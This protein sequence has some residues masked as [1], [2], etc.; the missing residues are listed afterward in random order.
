MKIII[1]IIAL[2]G[3]MT[4]GHC[5]ESAKPESADKV[6]SKPYSLTHYKKAPLSMSKSKSSSPKFGIRTSVIDLDKNCWGWLYYG[7]VRAPKDAKV[8][9][10]ATV[11][12]S[13]QASKLNVKPLTFDIEIIE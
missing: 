12:V 8:G 3:C 11:T 9:T 13:F 4:Y 1:V 10:K 7:S 2:L 5:Q 6:K